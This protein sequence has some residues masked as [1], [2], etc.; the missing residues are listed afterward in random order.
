LK[1][2]EED[3]ESLPPPS[4]NNTEEGHLDD[5]FTNSLEWK[6]KKKHIFILSSAGK[7]VYSR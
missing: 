6:E 3:L 7:P 5:D 2:S 1:I 4:E